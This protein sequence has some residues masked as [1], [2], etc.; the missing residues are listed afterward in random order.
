MPVFVNFDIS[1][2][3]K[4]SSF[5]SKEIYEHFFT[6][7]ADNPKSHKCSSCGT[8]DIDKW[9]KQDLKKGYQNILTHMDINHPG[10]LNAMPKKSEKQETIKKDGKSVNVTQ[11]NLGSS[12]KVCCL[13]GNFFLSISRPKVFTAGLILW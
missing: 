6:V 9:V 12:L 1:M 3:R 2:T 10:Y 5:T 8:L 7:S 13:D 11:T 4:P